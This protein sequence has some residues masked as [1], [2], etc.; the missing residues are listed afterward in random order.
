MLITPQDVDKLISE[1]ENRELALSSVTQTDRVKDY[2][3]KI[4]EKTTQLIDIKSRFNG[5]GGVCHGE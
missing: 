2:R 5:K 4:Q 3:L 1:L